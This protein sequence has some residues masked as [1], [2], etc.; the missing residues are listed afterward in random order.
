[1]SFFEPISGADF[2]QKLEQARAVEGARII[3]VRSTVEYGQGHV[4]GAE[5]IPLNQ[6]PLLDAPKDTPIFLYCRS[7]ARSSQACAILQQRGYE[8]VNIGGI[9]SYTGT[10][11]QGGTEE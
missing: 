10:L 5:N 4:P 1:M 8:G 7:G 6:I 11:E 2:D 9:L 3:D